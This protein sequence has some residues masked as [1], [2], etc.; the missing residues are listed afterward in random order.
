MRGFNFIAFLFGLFTYLSVNGQT[1][2]L[3]IYPA[4]PKPGDTVKIV[5]NNS[6]NV[7]L[8]NEAVKCIV[9]KWGEYADDISIT[10]LY[11]QSKPVE[12]SLSKVGDSYQGSFITDSLTR[13]LSFS[14]FSGYPKWEK[15]NL[16]FKLVSGKVDNNN[17]NG[18]YTLLYKGLVPIQ[19]S[20]FFAGRY[21]SAELNNDIRIKNYS[22]AVSF[23][24]KEMQLYP[25]SKN[26]TLVQWISPSSKID[27]K[28]TADEK[29]KQ[30]EK[31]YKEGLKSEDDMYLLAL[32][33]IS[34]GLKEQGAYYLKQTKE[35][36]NSKKGFTEYLARLNEIRAEKNTENAQKLI[37]SLKNFYDSL[38]FLTK[39]KLNG[40]NTPQKTKFDLLYQLFENDD[41]DKMLAYQSANHLSVNLNPYEYSIYLKMADSSLKQ[42]KGV[43]V[44][45]KMTS[46]IQQYY[47]NLVKLVEKNKYPENVA[48]EYLTL[49]EKKSCLYI[50]ASLFSLNQA[51]FDYLNSKYQSAWDNAIKAKKY[52]TQIPNDFDQLSKLNEWYC[53]IAEKVLPYEKTVEEIEK[54]LTSGI[55]SPLLLDQLKDLWIKKNASE[56]GFKTYLS[57]L[58]KKNSETLNAKKLNIPS[59][60]FELYNLNGQLVKLSDYKGKIVI[61]DFWATWCVPC[62]ASF[63]GMQKMVNYFKN[64][65]DI[66]FLFINTMENFENKNLRKTAIKDILNKDNYSFHV[67]LDDGSNTAS[68]FAIEAIP[69][70]FLIDKNGIIRYKVVGFER[71]NDI[72]FTEM[73]KMIESIQ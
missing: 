55:S 45:S 20:N 41:Y 39:M 43:V 2:N 68:R 48:G 13:F 71:N 23:F 25:N 44:I 7:F 57:G 15:N 12:V 56:D 54:V 5:Y 28:K 64:N 32:L 46:E 40:S 11:R 60:N 24:E 30:I 47:S 38:D 42:N 1:T 50:A 63:P 22:L 10:A 26:Y 3:N 36:Y 59:P 61:L 35:L 34:S 29:L 8:A 72:L 9:Y 62:R 58:L 70:K 4:N 37:S 19:L 73:N 33:S 49:N 21:F 52:A 51:R 6:N 65:P 31:I 18:F 67:L 16:E 27:P 14:F 17:N 69:A 66:V 53:K